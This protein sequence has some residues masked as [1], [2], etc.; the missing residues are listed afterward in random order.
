MLENYNTYRILGVF[1]D[2][3]AR[4][5]QLREISRLTH[6]SL[7]SVINHV[8]SLE[9]QGFLRK[10]KNGVY[11]SYSADK[12]KKFK[13][14][15]RNDI[16]LRIEETGLIEFI[17]DRVQPNTIVLFG[18]AAR[19]EDVEDSDID[20]FVLSEEAELDLKSFEDKLK[21][22]IRIMFEKDIRELPKELMNNIINGI[23]LYGY[24][25]VL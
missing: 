11:E 10:R 25:K 22:K 21:R 4:N 20:L 1:F 5:F 14:Y 13:V 3:P 8:K 15:K 6:I 23:I 16:L 9:K 18:S 19:G 12:T 7:P 2:S 17:A 24:L